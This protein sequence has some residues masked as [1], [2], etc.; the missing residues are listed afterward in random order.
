MSVVYTLRGFSKIPLS[1]LYLAMTSTILSATHL[2]SIHQ[3]AQKYN[4]YTFDF[5]TLENPLYEL[6]NYAIG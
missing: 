5:V 6:A 1:F 4:R 2:F 3:V